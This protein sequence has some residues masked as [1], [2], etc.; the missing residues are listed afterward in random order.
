MSRNKD[1]LMKN[2]KNSTMAQW[3]VIV[4]NMDKKIIGVFFFKQKEDADKFV[5]YVQED[6]NLFTDDSPYG[7]STGTLQEAKE[8]L[9]EALT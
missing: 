3:F 1:D 7:V 5:D 4:S 9:K 8:S 2:V 6:E